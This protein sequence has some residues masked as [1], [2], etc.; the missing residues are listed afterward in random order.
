MT[1]INTQA[2]KLD[3][4][5]KTLNE[6]LNKREHVDLFDGFGGKSAHQHIVLV[7]DDGIT[8]KMHQM[9]IRKHASE[10]KVVVFDNPQ[11]ALAYISEHEPDL[12]LLDLHMPDIDGWRFLEMMEELNLFIDVVI[13]SSSIDPR[14]HSKAKSF[15]CVKDFYTKPL[16][17]EKV[18]QLLNH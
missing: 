13:V 14:E 5:I 6:V 8:N 17:I 1:D 10:K 7:D 4:I 12:I 16:T 11:K 15:L 2:V 18:N 9:L 3:E